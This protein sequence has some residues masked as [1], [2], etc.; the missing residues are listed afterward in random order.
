GVVGGGGGG[1]DGGGGR[2]GAGA[3]QLGGGEAVE[4]GHADVHQHHVRG[5]GV[6]HGGHLGSIGCLAHQ[7]QVGR[8]ADDHREAGP[9]ERVIV[10]DEDPDRGVHLG[11]G[12]HAQSRKSPAAVGP[13][14]SR[15]PA[16]LA[17]S[18]SPIR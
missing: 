11:H 12:S 2:G 18:V 7:G 9:D 4:R 10:D 6:Y 15:P 16:R 13:C 1:E 8:A 3:E 5:V 14:S 17:R